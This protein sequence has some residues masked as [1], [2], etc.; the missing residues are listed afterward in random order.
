MYHRFEENKYP[1]TN[2]RMNIFLKHIDA[3]NNN[4]FEFYNPKLLNEQFNVPKDNKKICYK[5]LHKRVS[6]T[7]NDL[8]KLDEGILDFVKKGF[9]SAKD[10][11]IK[12]GQKIRD[13]L[14]K[15]LKAVFNRFTNTV[16]N[17]FQTKPRILFG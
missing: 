11:I 4:G 8:K 13:I 2:I 15:F 1:S 16:K 6:K 9:K 14:T 10:A 5:Q 12:V 17:L 3:V 7:A